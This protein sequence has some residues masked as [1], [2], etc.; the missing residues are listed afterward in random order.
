MGDVKKVRIMIPSP[1]EQ[2]EIERQYA[3]VRELREKIGKLETRVEKMNKEG[4]PLTKITV[5]DPS[6]K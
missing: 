6:S 4:W 2:R 1:G 3:E 5:A